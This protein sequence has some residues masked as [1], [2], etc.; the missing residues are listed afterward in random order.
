[1]WQEMICLDSMTDTMNMNLSK[2]WE[3]I[4]DREPWCTEVHWVAEPDMNY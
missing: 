2:L 1:M 3:I 4:K